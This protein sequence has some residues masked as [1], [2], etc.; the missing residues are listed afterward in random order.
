VPFLVA[1]GV[2]VVAAALAY[3]YLREDP[4]ELIR[5]DRLTAIGDDRVRA[6]VT[7]RGPCDRILRAQVDLAEEAVF[8]ELVVERSEDG[9]AGRASTSGIDITLPEPIGDRDLRPGI[10]RHQIPCSDE[11]PTVTCTPDR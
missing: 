1:L 7:D 5:P 2:V 10:G 11:R 6:V 9:C 4:G 3:V 8:V